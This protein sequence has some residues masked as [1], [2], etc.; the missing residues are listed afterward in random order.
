M[1]EVITSLLVLAAVVTLLLGSGLWA[2][3]KAQ[4]HD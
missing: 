2:L 4:F 1:R 3:F